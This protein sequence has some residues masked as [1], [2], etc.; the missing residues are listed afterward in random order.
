MT[1]FAVPQQ[2]DS[3]YNLRVVQPKCPHDQPVVLLGKGERKYSGW[4]RW[5]PECVDFAPYRYVLPTPE[6]TAAIE[7]RRVGVPLPQNPGRMGNE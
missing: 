7:R 4:T 3:L 5:C 2:V 6:Q 1:S